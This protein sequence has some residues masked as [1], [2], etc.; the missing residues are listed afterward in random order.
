MKQPGQTSFE[1]YNAAGIHPGKTHDG[2][3]V[4]TWE[5]LS[6]DVRAKWA[7]A[8][9]AAGRLCLEQFAPVAMMPGADVVGAF[10]RAQVRYSGECAMHNAPLPTRILLEC[11]ED[12]LQRLG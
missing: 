6:D 7:V 9:R 10:Q 12:E 2:K 4:P 5:N 11:F 1:S 3:P 8:E